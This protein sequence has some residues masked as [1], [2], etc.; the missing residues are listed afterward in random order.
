[1]ADTA[2]SKKRDRE[3]DDGGW[4]ADRGG[5]R[6]RQ[7]DIEFGLFLLGI[8]VVSKEP[9]VVQLPPGWPR[10]LLFERT[11]RRGWVFL[12]ARTVEGTYHWRIVFSAE[13][14]VCG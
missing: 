5:G 4:F 8:G 1:M 14:L 6:G 3:T 7:A 9:H 2:A 10:T 11:L 12:V 13:N